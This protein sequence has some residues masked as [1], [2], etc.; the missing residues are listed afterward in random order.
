MILL[1]SNNGN[2]TWASKCYTVGLAGAI[3][4]ASRG[5]TWAILDLAGVAGTI[6]GAAGVILGL[7]R[8]I[9]C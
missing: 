1:V 5:Y 8:A 3:L 2:Y 9:L 6:L 4:K 7:A